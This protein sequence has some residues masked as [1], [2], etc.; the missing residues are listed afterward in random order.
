MS[1]RL[2]MEIQPKNMTD[3]EK[4]LCKNAIAEY[5]TI[6][7]IVQMGN[8]YRLVSPYDKQGVASLMYVDDAK[9]KAVFYWW[10]TETFVNQHLPRVKMAGLDA[11]K[12]YRIHELNRLDNEPLAFEGNTFSGAYLM[13]NGLE[14]PYTHNVDHHK[15][16][17]WASRVLVIEE[18]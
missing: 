13:A 11:N 7:P 3:E 2:G 9:Q 1:G 18:D 12:T 8:I 4:A 14:I 15:K 16:T 6:R 17:A 10:K 5:K